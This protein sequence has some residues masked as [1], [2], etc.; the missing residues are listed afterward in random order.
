MRQ[1]RRT[2]AVPVLVVLLAL[3]LA[4]CI[5]PLPRPGTETPTPAPSPPPAPAAT[6]T[7]APTPTPVPT[8]PPAPTPRPA[9]TP[10]PPPTPTPVPEATP[11]PTPEPT[12]PP[13]VPLLLLLEPPEEFSTAN[14]VLVVHGTTR[15]GTIVHVNNELA[16][17]DDEGR[18][19]A[20]VLLSSGQ[21][22]VEVVATAEDGEQ[23]TETRTVTFVLSKPLFLSV[24]EPFDRSVV[25]ER[26]TDV[27]GLTASDAQILVNGEPVEVQMLPVDAPV[28]EVG[29]FR[30]FVL[31]ELGPNLVEVTAI[32]PT[33]RKLT[34]TVAVIYRP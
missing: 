20:G 24:S 9:P 22:P 32:S 10:T 4:A 5:Q 30:T 26:V 7:P 2:H 3:L 18:F 17:V 21:N 31:L 15:P 28:E 27:S 11:T 8:A 6:A 12:P 16:R 33:G 34:T 19:V 1:S 29:A 23:A 25:S 13:E 14:N